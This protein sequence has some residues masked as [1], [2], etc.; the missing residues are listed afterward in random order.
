MPPAREGRRL[1]SMGA[2][3]VRC[4]TG[5]SRSIASGLAPLRPRFTDARVGGEKTE[6]VAQRGG[7]GLGYPPTFKI[8]VTKLGSS[9]I[10]LSSKPR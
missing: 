1:F 9:G 2:E 6:A 3:S 7:R 4:G 5:G 10:G 8:A